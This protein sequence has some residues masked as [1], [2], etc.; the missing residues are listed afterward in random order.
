[1]TTASLLGS[2]PIRKATYRPEIDGLRALAVAAVLINHLDEHALPG[3][4]LGVD[5]FFVISGYV[6]TASLLARKDDGWRDFL[7]RFYQRRFRRLLPALIINV[8]VVSIVFSAFASP[9]DDVRVPSLRT[10]L[11][12]LFGFSNIYLWKQGTDYFAANTQ[13]NP[14][15]H[16]WS[17]G[18]EEQFYLLWPIVL[19]ACGVGIVGARQAV[20]KL[21]VMSLFLFTA[22]LA[23]YLY[24][25]FS[26]HTEAAFFLMPARFWELSIGC[27]AFIFHSRVLKGAAMPSLRVRE[28]G[29]VVVMV[30]ILIALF[31]SP[32][33]R[34][35]ATLWVALM[36]AVQLVL[37]DR[38]S[39]I[40]RMLSQPF[41]LMVGL[42]SYS[43][44]LWHWP[45]IV[46]A[47]WTWGITW[48][49]MIPILLLILML[50]IVSY[51]IEIYFRQRQ[52]GASI[53]LHPLLL[54]PSLSLLTGAVVFMLQG[55]MK[56]MLFVGDRSGQ[57][58]DSANMK[59]ISGTTVNTVNCF[60]E[61]T[62]KIDAGNVFEQCLAVSD[63]QSPTLYFVGDS[64]TNSIMPL[65]DRLFQVDNYSVAFSARGG[66]PFPDFSL[67][68]MQ[69]SG[70][71]RYRLCAPHYQ[72]QLKQI[73]SI[74]KP[75]DF[76]ILVSRLVGHFSSPN[77][78]ELKAA[79]AAYEE[80]IGLLS[81]ALQDKGAQLII[82]APMP[83][84][85]DR[86]RLV[87]PITTCKAE[88]Y[89]PEA[90]MPSE[91]K[92][93]TVN[94]KQYLASVARIDTMLEQVQLKHPNVFVYHPVDEICPAEL[95]LCST[96]RGTDILFSDDTHLTN[97]GALSLYPSFRSF[98]K[99]VR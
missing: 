96:H 46:L 49:T 88:W 61:P 77:P 15:T 50:S 71:G 14:F 21:T 29:G 85:S 17:L 39:Q 2:P 32:D 93:A 23:Y 69:G 84:F 51:R 52:S 48:L 40:G 74:I 8:L 72:S 70:D 87:S 42:M 6:V 3:G 75:G 76:L 25:S 27:L 38:N 58:M 64:H 34:V 94:R 98:L 30:G 95:E 26:G 82:F 67:P 11:T 62:A 83:S 60:R 12:S 41:C 80:Q 90:G 9:L 4:Y 1:M 7:S 89:R 56:W 35:R 63:K 18:V 31:A 28:L 10:G 45:V 13:F 22:S 99:T 86:A 59:R 16:T 47:R 66:C 5:I 36:T 81:S 37:I 19:L 65:G 54:Y 55:T 73:Y 33:L 92:P 78:A 91:C 43:L 79:E 97:Y 20:K 68:G 24:L 57:Q 53:F 44:Y